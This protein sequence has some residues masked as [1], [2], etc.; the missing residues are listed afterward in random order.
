MIKK[1]YTALAKFETYT[2]K[3]PTA[4]YLGHETRKQ[5]LSE[6]LIH[7]WLSITQNVKRPEFGEVPIF[8]VDAMEHFNIG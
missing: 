5:L 3:R 1:L 8:E 4:I 6:P 7:N 2:G